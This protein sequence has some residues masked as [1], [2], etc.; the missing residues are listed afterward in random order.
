MIQTVSM[1]FDYTFTKL[2]ENICMGNDKEF[3]QERGV[4]H[5]SLYETTAVPCLY[6]STRAASAQR[7]SLLLSFRSLPVRMKNRKTKNPP[8]QRSAF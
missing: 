6:Y 5:T 7:L 2:S 3:E 1:T 4:V 8:V